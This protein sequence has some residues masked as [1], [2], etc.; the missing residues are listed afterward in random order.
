MKGLED[1]WRFGRIGTSSRIC[2]RQRLA[3]DDVACCKGGAT[4]ANQAAAAAAGGRPTIAR[5]RQQLCSHLPD[6]LDVKM[7]DRF[8]FGSAAAPVASICAYSELPTEG[9]AGEGEASTVPFT[10]DVL[11]RVVYAPYSIQPL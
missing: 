1:Q 6:P 2:C 4:K 8:F 11:Q 3:A 9:A 7:D 5:L 10:S